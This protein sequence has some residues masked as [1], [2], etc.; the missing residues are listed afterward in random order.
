[1]SGDSSILGEVCAGDDETDPAQTAPGSAAVQ[2]DGA[3]PLLP[4]RAAVKPPDRDLFA[5]KGQN[6]NL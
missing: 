1:M 4:R 2:G 6:R 3:H 5:G